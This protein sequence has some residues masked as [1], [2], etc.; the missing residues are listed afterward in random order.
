M[1]KITK[2][3]AVK[4]FLE[5]YL[6]NENLFNDFPEF[7]FLKPICTKA[8]ANKCTCGM[9]Q[10]IARATAVFNDFVLELNQLTV[11][12]LKKTFEING[13]L[14]FGLQ[15]ANGDFGIKCYP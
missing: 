7:G 14:C 10:E 12:K 2:T 3:I 6:S 5:K 9:G 13:T 4:D 8:K 15:Q 1:D 11:E